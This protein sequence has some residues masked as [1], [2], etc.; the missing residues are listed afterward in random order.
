MTNLEKW[1]LYT[2]DLVSPDAFIDMG[3]YYMIA[4]ALQRRVWYGPDQDM[5][6]PNVYFIL[7]GE[8][9]VGKGL[10]LGKINYFLRFFERRDK[11]LN[12]SQL[13]LLIRK[14]IRT[15]E[16]EPTVRDISREIYEVAG[17]KPKQKIT[18]PT[19]LFPMAA[20][21]TTYAALT[22]SFAKATRS[23]DLP[24]NLFLAPTGKYV[25]KSLS[26][27]LEELSSLF[28]KNADQ[29]A[30]FFLCAFD[31]KDYKYETKHQGTDIL[32]KPCLNFIGGTTP[33]FMQKAFNNTMLNDGFCAR[34]IF[35]YEFSNRHNKFKIEDLDHEQLEARADLLKHLHALAQ[36]VGRCRMTDEAEEFCRRY[37]EV[38]LPT[39]RVR[40]NKSQKLN[41]YYARK[42]VHT[43]KLAMIVHYAD[44]L[45][46][47][48]TLQDIHTALRILESVEAKMH[49]ALTFGENPLAKIQKNIIR[50][51]QGLSKM[52]TDPVVVG[53]TFEELWIEFADDVREEELREC[54]KYCL[55]TGLIKTV[56]HPKNAQDL[57]LFSPQ[58]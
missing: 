28:N 44:A 56:R 20:E 18:E 37:F 48:I 39:G 32:R 9:G 33:V 14:G 52:S 36:L 40:I 2:R 45:D 49:Y 17:D 26:F 6:F 3:F 42:K 29:I 27:C 23:I 16:T 31:C 22:G 46:N 58:H 53:K 47:L 19:L 10:V 50:Y 43:I 8:P 12:A 1:R 41:H 21:S 38:E 5:L 35:V 4:S 15:H 11:D 55:T 7:V 30:D 34:S 25:Y 54:L 51:L 13:D 24:E 57:Y